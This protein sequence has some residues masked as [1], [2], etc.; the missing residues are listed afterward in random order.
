M[1]DDIDF[2]ISPR[3][4][5][6]MAAIGAGTPVAVI[7][8]DARIK[9]LVDAMRIPH[10]D[11]EQFFKQKP[12]LKGFVKMTK[13]TDFDVFEANRVEKLATWKGVL[14]EANIEMD[15]KLLSIVNAHGSVVPTLA[16]F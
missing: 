16:A 4:H 8:I 14:A 10:V 6:S 12:Y 13:Y 3:I 11:K 2:V 7:P 1:E 5:G 9:E 15:P